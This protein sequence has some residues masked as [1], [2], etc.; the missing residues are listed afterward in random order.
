LK[1]KE[2]QEIIAKHKNK[3]AKDFLLNQ[4]AIAGI[5]N[6]YADESLFI[7]RIH[8]L[9][10]VGTLNAERQKILL[11]AIQKVL[12]KAIASGGSSIEYF[13]MIDGGSG[14]FAEQH[15]VYAKAGLPCP[16]CG[17]SLK[18]KKIASRTAT[19]CDNC[20]K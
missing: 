6:I 12:R 13:L 3:R 5:G 17:K 16:N 20:Q 10:K 14:K 2:F 18:S 7:S 1:L 9:R 15:L 19:Y 8:P 11:S 4:E